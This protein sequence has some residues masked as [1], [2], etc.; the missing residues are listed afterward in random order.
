MNATK[1]DGRANAGASAA[2]EPK[3]PPA[4]PTG[5]DRAAQAEAA[6]GRAAQLLTERRFADA[7]TALGEAEQFEAEP[8]KWKLERA[9]QAEAARTRAAQMLSERRF[10]EAKSAL[11]EAEKLDA[12]PPKWK[13]ESH[14]MI[15][16]LRAK[17][18]KRKTDDGTAETVAEET[19][20]GAV[21]KSLEI[22]SFYSKVAA[23][24]GLLPGGLLNF[25]GVLAVEATMVWKIANEFGHTEGKER[26]RGSILS[27]IG[28]VIPAGLGHGAGAAIAAIPAL[29]AGTIVYFVATP[30]LAYAMTQAVGN[31]FI[32]HFE[33]GGTLLTFDSKAFG[34]YF[35]KEYR[36][37]GGMIVP[38]VPEMKP[39][40]K[41]EVKPEVKAV[42]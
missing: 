39:E 1:K 4:D 22:V 23:G 10:D 11:E 5:P 19:G 42:P 37:A 3:Q 25:A 18:P 40:V 16:S 31:A 14:R 17:L 24:V 38:E 7:K 30:I 26:I 2:E 32:M 41:A 27:L 21:N 8:P 15:S 29:I 36:K 13:T 34:E 28:A 33:S 35:L 20:V 12:E 9:A 6:R